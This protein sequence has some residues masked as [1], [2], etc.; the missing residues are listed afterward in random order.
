MRGAIPA[1]IEVKYGVE[2]SNEGQLFLIKFHLERCSLSPAGEKN[3]NRSQSR[4][5]RTGT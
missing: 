4:P 2:E 5:I 1:T 3:E